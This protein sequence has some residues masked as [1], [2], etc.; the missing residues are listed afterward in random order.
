MF[1]AHPPPG[2]AQASTDP[3]RA[4]APA[5]GGSRIGRI[6][7]LLGGLITYGKHLAYGLRCCAGTQAFAF[8]VKPFGT[9]DLLA[10]LVHIARGLRL[11]DALYQ[12]LARRAAHGRDLIPPKLRM[13]APLSLR[14][15][16]R[17]V[18]SNPPRPR[19]RPAPD[20]VTLPTPEELA[21][22]LH[23]PLGAV[24]ADICRDL[25]ITPGNVE[26]E[27]WRELQRAIIEYGGSLSRY[28]IETNRRVFAF[29]PAPVAHV[30]ASLRAEQPT[31]PVETPQPSPPLLPTLATGPPLNVPVAA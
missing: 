22:L 3:Q 25:G 11:A 7:G 30:P 15:P 31:E 17:R 13:P 23:R 21:A 27:L 10:I 6:L 28:L 9:T 18:G 29:P 4:S 1:M 16:P 26:P 12:R 19:R 5:Q 8:R 24:I 2:P 14:P 20:D